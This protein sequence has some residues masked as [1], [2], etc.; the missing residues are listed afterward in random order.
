MLK[1]SHI[2][3]V[4]IYSTDWDNIRRGRMTSSR[5]S[6]IMGKSGITDGG[7]TY[8]YHKAGEAITGQ[9]HSDEEI[10]EDENTAWGRENEPLAIRKFGV[11][12]GIEFLVTEKVIC[13]QSTQFSSTPDAIWVHGQSVL[14]SDEYNVSTL[15]VKCPKKYHKFIPLFRCKTPQD[16]K[17]FNK[18][19]YWQVID[20][21][22]ICG[23]AVGY[24]ACFNPLFP[25]KKNISIIR[26]D[27][28]SLWD[29]FKLLIKRKEEALSVFNAI[30]QE[31]LGN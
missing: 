29:D 26:F 13:D 10:L 30:C 2:T 17:D 9:S 20:Q 12:M 28:H 6:S 23:S 31:F 25:E 22:L 5:I 18:V 21:M 14:Q 24:F 27:K 3:N 19:Y 15:E 1:K 16:L 11:I 4:Q 8:I 7:M